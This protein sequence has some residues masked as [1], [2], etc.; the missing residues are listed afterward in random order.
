MKY[1]D[2]NAL[3]FYYFLFPVFSVP[4]LNHTATV[5]ANIHKMTKDVN[6]TQVFEDTG[7]PTIPINQVSF[8]GD[9]DEFG[10]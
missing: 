9:E 6:W 1:V 2:E 10:C 7:C 8:E 4:L 3:N 5:S